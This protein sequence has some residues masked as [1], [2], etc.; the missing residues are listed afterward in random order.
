MLTTPKHAWRVK[1][2]LTLSLPFGSMTCR[3]LRVTEAWPWWWGEVE[4]MWRWTQIVRVKVR[5]HATKIWCGIPRGSRGRF[6]PDDQTFRGGGAPVIAIWKKQ[7]YCQDAIISTFEVPPFM[8]G[9]CTNYN[10]GTVYSHHVKVPS[11]VKYFVKSIII[12]QGGPF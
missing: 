1:I 7:I 9:R 4:V 6:G 12:E 2:S 8:Q 3:F 5:A 10:L 11:V